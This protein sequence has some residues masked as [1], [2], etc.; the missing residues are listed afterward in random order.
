M[1]L[2]ELKAQRR[3]LDEKIK[4]LENG[5]CIA[6]GAK[7]DHHTYPRGTE[8]YIAV[9][10]HVDEELGASRWRAIITCKEK[11]DVIKHINTVINDLIA[12]KGKL[13]KEME[14]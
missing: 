6:G 7:L 4:E 9:R 12:L 8:W 11:K 1:T 5:G 13:L 14:D 2:E 3:E 10:S